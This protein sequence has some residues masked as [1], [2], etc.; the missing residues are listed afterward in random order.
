MVAGAWD[1]F[2]D[3]GT[4]RAGRQGRRPERATAR[5]EMACSR[6][7]LVRGTSSAG[8]ETVTGRQGRRPER[9][10]A[11][12][13]VVCSRWSR[14]VGEDAVPARRAGLRAGRAG[15]RSELPL[16]LR[17]SAPDGRGSWG[18]DRSR[19]GEPGYGAGRAGGRSELPLEL[20]WSAPDGRGS[21]DETGPGSESRATGRQGRRPERATARAEMVCSRWSRVVGESWYPARRAGLRRRA[22]RGIRVPARRAGLRELEWRNDAK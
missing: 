18:R 1:G 2:S 15:G 19:L 10:T 4:S 21:W 22:G 13:E 16:E 14:V 20:R 3:S 6:W 7:S 11:R 8:S 9:A 17:W 12:A 5:A